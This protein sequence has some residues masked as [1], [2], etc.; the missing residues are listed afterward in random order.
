MFPRI[1][2]TPARSASAMGAVSSTSSDST[3]SSKPV[4]ATARYSSAAWARGLSLPTRAS[5]ASAT[6]G[7][8]RSSGDARTSVTKNGFP[9][10]SRNKVLASTAVSAASSATASALRR[11]QWQPLGSGQ[12]AEQA[13]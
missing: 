2:R 11:W 8:T 1:R 7:G 5:T 6:V 9:S 13:A 3:G 4:G 10:V 12:S